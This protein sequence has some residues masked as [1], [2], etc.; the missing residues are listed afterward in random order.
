VNVITKRYLQYFV[1]IGLALL[2]LRGQGAEPAQPV[3]VQADCD[4]T[5]P[6]LKSF[7]SA[8]AQDCGRSCQELGECRGWS[9]IS[10][11]NRCFLKKSVK[12][13]TN[14][15]MYAGQ[16][17]RSGEAAKIAIEGWQKDDSGKDYK[18]VAPVKTADD[19]KNVCLGE[20]QCKAFVFIEGYSV[21]WLK[22]TTGRFA[23][24]VFS[25]GLS[26]R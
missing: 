15:R 9:H 23:D 24:K 16:V 3:S 8:S 5:G 4:I 20:S 25:C 22:K 21:C 12:S 13:K 17:D 19:C 6:D 18:R 11:W 2:S 1:I 10:G 26:S 14:V 7:I